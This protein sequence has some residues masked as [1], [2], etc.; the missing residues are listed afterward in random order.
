VPKIDANQLELEEKVVHINRVAKVVKGGRRFS[1]AAMVVVGDY[2]GH[3]GI[4]LGKGH[5][6]PV[7]I[8]KAAQSAKK[9]LI[10]VPLSGQTITHQIVGAY[11]AGR[12]LLKP[13]APG[14]GIIAGGPVRAVMEL[15][16]VKD[17]L[18]KSLGSENS[19]N[20]VKAT[21]EGLKNL[22][23]QETVEKNRGVKVHVYK[24]AIKQETGVSKQAAEKKELKGEELKTEA[25]EVP[26]AKKETKK[27]ESKKVETKEKKETVKAAEKK[28]EKPKVEKASDSASTD[29]KAM[30][31][32]E[33]TPDKEPKEKKEEDKK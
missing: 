18:A 7:A 31:D 22:L 28:E 12:V 33:A 25:K 19:I 17:V 21:I 11:G 24:Q 20:M 16:G 9:N 23:D 14:T 4:G 32:K 29:A 8:N 3:V 26:K 13:A 5:E 1:L 2:Q 15:A 6:V 30:V 27:E 10:K